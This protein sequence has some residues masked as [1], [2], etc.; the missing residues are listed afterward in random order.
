MTSPAADAKR[1]GNEHF[2]NGDFACAY[3]CYTR[4]IQYDPR[5][6]AL[7][8]NRATASARLERPADALL[9]ARIA[10]KLRPAWSKAYFRAA[11]ALEKVEDMTAAA[12]FYS[13]ALRLDPTERLVSQRLAA[14]RLA[15][16]YPGGETVAR[17]NRRPAHSIGMDGLE[18]LCDQSRRHLQLWADDP[19]TA[20]RVISTLAAVPVSERDKLF[21]DLIERL[22]E[23]KLMQPASE[24][25]SPTASAAPR[26]RFRGFPK[27]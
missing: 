11:E 5:D 19:A 27:V 24:R 12:A 2:Q 4:A 26:V 16:S 15:S 18:G 14:A 3:E 7:Y 22:H 10:I 6:A 1:E 9:D 17:T 23:L 8:C 25:A 20:P 13:E 21:M